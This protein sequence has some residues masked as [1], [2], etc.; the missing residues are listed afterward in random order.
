MG[1]RSDSG[2][3]HSAFRY[4]LLAIYLAI[5]AIRCKIEEVQLFHVDNSTTLGPG[6]RRLAQIPIDGNGEAVPT[7]NGRPPAWKVRCCTATEGRKNGRGRV[8]AALPVP[9]HFRPGRKWPPRPTPAQSRETLC[10][11]L[12][13]PHALSLHSFSR[14]DTTLDTKTPISVCVAIT[15]ST[16]TS[17]STSTDVG[18]AAEPSHASRLLSHSPARSFVPHSPCPREELLWRVEEMLWHCGQD[19]SR[20]Y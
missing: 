15:T 10:V 4:I 1:A 5:P 19:V 8:V 20:M 3:R 2:H 18:R 13:S 11:L 14:H 17:T 6:Q 16:S 9:V 12:R 7:G